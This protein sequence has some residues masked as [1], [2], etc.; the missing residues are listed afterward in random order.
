MSITYSYNHEGNWA[1][2]FLTVLK[3]GGTTVPTANIQVAQSMTISRSPRIEVECE[4]DERASDQMARM[5]A[6]G[7][8][9]PQLSTFTITNFTGYDPTNAQNGYRFLVSPLNQAT[10]IYCGSPTLA[11]WYCGVQ[12]T[13]ATQ[14]TVIVRGGTSAAPGAVLAALVANGDAVTYYASTGKLSVLSGEWYYSHRAANMVTRIVTSR[15]AE[16]AQDHGSIRARV[17]YLFSREAQT[18]VSPVVTIYQTL[19]V[20][21]T[22]SNVSVRDPDG[23]REDVTEFR[24]RIE[25]GIL[26]TTVPTI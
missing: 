6:S 10:E 15:T 22:G 25:Y 26:P 11:N 1:A 13:D 7:A 17:R 21:D 16:T 8:A 9:Y 4:S 14:W 5:E 20:Q 19:D 18:L 2:A 3:S 12:K 24:H 23:D